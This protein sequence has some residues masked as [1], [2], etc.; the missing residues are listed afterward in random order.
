MAVRPI[1]NANYEISQKKPKKSRRPAL[2]QR[3]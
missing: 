3:E 2:R 1:E